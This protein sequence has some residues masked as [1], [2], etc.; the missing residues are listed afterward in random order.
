MKEETRICLCLSMGLF[1]A[2]FCER[3]LQSTGKTV[4][5]MYSQGAG[6]ITNIIMDP[7]LIFGMFGL[8]EMGVAGAALATVISQLVSAIWVLKFLTSGK[9]SV[10]LCRKS[11]R[12]RKDI[13]RNISLVMV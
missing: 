3:M 13:T 6:A 7:I 9:A 10:R 12:I 1:I 5:S 2:I 8:P 4:Y 11:I